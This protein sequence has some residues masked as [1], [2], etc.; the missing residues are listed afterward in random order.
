MSKKLSLYLGTILGGL[1]V[2]WVVSNR[3]KIKLK[4]EIYQGTKGAT[5]SIVTKLLLK[6]CVNKIVRILLR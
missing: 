5:L 3:Q 6:R 2:W 4:G 1:L